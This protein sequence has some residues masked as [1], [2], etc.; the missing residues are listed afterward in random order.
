MLDPLRSAN[1][2][3]PLVCAR[4]ATD[5]FG[6]VNMLYGLYVGTLHSNTRSWLPRGGTR[7][8]CKCID[9]LRKV[10]AGSFRRL[11]VDSVIFIG[12]GNEHILEVI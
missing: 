8:D 7:P 2:I 3:R 12:V 1:S 5:P 9:L 4:D 10:K 6:L 11:R